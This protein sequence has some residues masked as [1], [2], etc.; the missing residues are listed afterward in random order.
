[1]CIATGFEKGLFISIKGHLCLT[2]GHLAKPQKQVETKSPS[3]EVIFDTTQ[4][5]EGKNSK[6]ALFNKASD[7][8]ILYL[9]ITGPGR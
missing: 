3:L 9:S 6:K 2:E 1:M 8:R 5:N 7:L 4:P